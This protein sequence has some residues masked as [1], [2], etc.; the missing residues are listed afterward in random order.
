MVK[1]DIITNIKTQLVAR[2]QQKQLSAYSLEDIAGLNRGAA[3]NIVNSRS[4]N[5][6]IE[7]LYAI[8]EVLECSIDDLLKEPA[9]S[10][11]QE[12]DRHDLLQK[13]FLETVNTTLKFIEQK[14]IHPNLD[15]TLFFIKKAY[16]FS[17]TRKN[18]V[19]D[20]EFLEWLIDNNSKK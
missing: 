2:M 14:N 6:K 11:L 16:I 20:L 1:K 18:K 9:S 10:S 4:K 12:E 7:T 3:N 5:P 15:E 17:L 19:L 13:L 8:A